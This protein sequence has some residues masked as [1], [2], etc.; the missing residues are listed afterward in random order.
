ME[1]VRRFRCV[2]KLPPDSG[3]RIRGRNPVTTV[4]RLDSEKRER[5]RMDGPRHRHF[6]KRGDGSRCGLGY[7][8]SKKEREKEGGSSSWET[9][10]RALV[11]G[12]GCGGRGNSERGGGGGAIGRRSMEGEQSSTWETKGE[13]KAPG[14]SLFYLATK[15]EAFNKGLPPLLPH[16]PA[17]ILIFSSHTPEG[18]RTHSL[19]SLFL[20][21][22]LSFFL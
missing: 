19:S 4:T 6:R 16:T 14:S 12:G 21:S 22:L 15:Q 7:T 3:I 9:T 18:T 17:L 20:C 11:S 13:E 2:L 8:G 5:E 1:S 10:Q